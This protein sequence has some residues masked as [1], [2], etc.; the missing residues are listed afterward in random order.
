MK[1]RV[2][3]L[4][5]FAASMLLAV[6]VADV[7]RSGETLGN[8]FLVGAV[9]AESEQEPRKPKPPTPPKRPE[10]GKDEKKD[11]KKEE[12]KNEKKE[13]KAEEKKEE[14][15][16]D[17]K[18]E[19]KEEKKDEKKDEA[20]KEEGHGEGGHGEGEEEDPEKKAAKEEAEKKAEERDRLKN[21]GVLD[22]SPAG[23]PKSG[24][25]LAPGSR[26]FSPIELE[27]LQT[28][29]KRREQMDRWAKDSEIKENLLADVEKR[30]D[31]KIVQIETLKKELTTM[32][33]T[34]NQQ[35]D[36]KIKSLVKIYE[37]MKP[38]DAARIFDEVEM[39]ILLLVIDKMAEKKA[40]PILAA[41]DSKKAKQL[42][43]E[44]AEQRRINSA[45]LAGRQAALAPSAAPPATAP[46]A[47]PAA[48]A[49]Q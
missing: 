11:E 21:G 38:R 18:E 30:I 28:L 7:M 41:M 12:K 10:P 6:K 46:A 44:L 8:A 25:G 43:V 23:D 48:P 19:K 33:A 26:Y 40:A 2:L 22:V 45:K 24:M 3:P 32:L 20:K 9:K 49:K 1:I 16:E 35:E 42:T 31:G 34:Y 13:E 17:K 47:A 29:D 15:K 27:I 39:P 5:M 14:K 36:A 37:S 4:T